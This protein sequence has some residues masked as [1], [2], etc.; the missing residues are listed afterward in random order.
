MRTLRGPAPSWAGQHEGR[1]GRK[2]Q[3]EEL[4]KVMEDV[5]Q[6]R[7]AGRT[8]SFQPVPEVKFF[9]FA[10]RGTRPVDGGA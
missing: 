10:F 2:R 6:Q 1:E 8:R 7:A 4:R 5:Q 9:I 3:D